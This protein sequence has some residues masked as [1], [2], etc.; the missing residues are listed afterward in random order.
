MA[1]FTTGHPPRGRWLPLLVA[2]ALLVP[3]ALWAVRQGVSRW[4][5]PA[6]IGT[7]LGRAPAPDFTLTDQRGQTVRLRDLRGQVVALTF[8][9]TSCRDVCP[10]VAENLRAA[11]EMLPAGAREDVALL[12]VTVDPA[13]DSTA[14]LQAF[15]ERHQLADSPGWHALRAD[16][17]T[18]EGVWRD[19]GI[20]PGLPRSSGEGGEGHT[21]AIYLIDREGRERVLLRSAA[22]D[23]ET[24]ADNLMALLD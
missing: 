23:P 10:L 1:T 17:S 14:A 15:S 13:R 24:L 18:L 21:D 20:Y 12:A 11:Y 5:E 9:Y 3:L 6:L 4:D 16:R 2:G 22:T 7:D 19:Y 8:I